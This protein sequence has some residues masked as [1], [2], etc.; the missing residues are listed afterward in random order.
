MNLSAQNNSNNENSFTTKESY[1]TFDV[2]S[3]LNVFSPR[4][5]VGYIKNI[6]PKW[7]VG[8]NLGYGYKNI[9]YT[10]FLDHFEENFKLWELRPEVY[11]VYKRNEKV[12]RYLSVELYYINHK[13]VFYDTYYYPKGGG[14]ISYD[15]T[16]YKRDK[17]GFNFNVGEFV[18]I[19]KHFGLNI[20]AGMGLR[21][22][23]V[24]F[25][26]I[27]DSRPS[28]TFV[29]MFDFN[30]YREKEG[31]DFGLSYSIGVKFLL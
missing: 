12:V 26:N 6:N 31:L 14:E 18:N 22:R 20:Y 19:R 17:Y 23:H 24:S 4:W 15:K 13:D 5:R 30:E 2:F 7:K 29:D 1:I 25:T 21:M 8:L 10:Y 28:E 27:V 9:S 11:K 16:D 3:S